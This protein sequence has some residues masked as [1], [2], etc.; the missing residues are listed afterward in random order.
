MLPSEAISNVQWS[1]QIFLPPLIFMLDQPTSL[2]APAS[3]HCHISLK[4]RFLITI[5][6]PVILSSVCLIAF[7][8]G[9]KIVSPSILPMF[10]CVTPLFSISGFV[11]PP[12][13]LVNSLDGLLY[14]LTKLY[15]LRTSFVSN[16]VRYLYPRSKS[17]VI[18]ITLTFPDWA[19]LIASR[20]SFS[21]SITL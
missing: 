17:F 20:K 18:S 4:W 15:F 21:S 9:E 6:L 1:T 8:F 10:I 3:S 13:T 7:P 5:S 16:S 12:F 14:S 2:C 11:N 19:S